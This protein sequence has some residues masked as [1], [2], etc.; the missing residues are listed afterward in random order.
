MVLVFREKRLQFDK[1]GLGLQSSE[2]VKSPTKKIKE[3]HEEMT[4][5]VGKELC[6]VH[7][8]V[9]RNLDGQSAP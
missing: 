4:R 6:R 5:G 2:K 3:F 1:S 9:L 7:N 8:Y